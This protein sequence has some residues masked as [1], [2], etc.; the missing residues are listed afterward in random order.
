MVRKYFLMSKVAIALSGGVDSSVTALLLKQQGFNV[1][2]ITAKT[3]NSE[4]ANI[5]VE[6]A[7]KVAD[8]LEIPFFV[9]DATK[10]FKEKVISYFENSYK[11]GETP[12]PCIMCNKYMKWGAL[13]DYAINKLESDYIA[14]GHYANI[15][16]SDGYYKLYPASD[17]HK[18]QLYFLFLL[19]Q[20]QLKRT[21]FPLSCFGKNDVRKIAFENDLPSKSSKESQDICFIQTPMTTKKYLNNIIKPQKGYF[22][23]NSSKK[24]LGSHTGFW[25]FTIGQR[26]GIGLASQEAL[27]V[28]GI[29]ARENIVYVGYKK[30]LL[31]KKLSLENFNWSYPQNNK[32][33]DAMVK[34]RYNMQAVPAHVEIEDDKVNIEFE[35]PVSA[36]AKGQACVLYNKQDGHLLGGAF[37]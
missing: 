25:Q 9:Y 3:T 22:I 11:S 34:I 28:T 30:S 35:E 26:K 17:E 24:I 36:I 18:D 10:I 12:N 6:N 14:T 32:N 13:F 8:K 23:E 4:A 16:H 15:K 21:L 19:N 31:S 2:G 20:N 29:N 27:Y 33:F 37:I 5:V 1:V 7:K